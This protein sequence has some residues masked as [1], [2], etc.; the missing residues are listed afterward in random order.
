[1]HILETI[2]EVRCVCVSVGNA[3]YSCHASSVFQ[4]FLPLS[5]ISPKKVAQTE[6]DLM[7]YVLD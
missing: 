6:K 7:K 2:I 1:M 3:V 5:S 4:C